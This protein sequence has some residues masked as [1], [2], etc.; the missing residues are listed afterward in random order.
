MFLKHA[1]IAHT[2][3]L[4]PNLT[5]SSSHHPNSLPNH[6]QGQRLP[7]NL[8]RL[9]PPS[10]HHARHPNHRTTPLNHLHIPP[11]LLKLA[12]LTP[13]SRPLYTLQSINHPLF[14][15]PLP[16]PPP[17]NHPLFIHPLPTPQSLL[18]LQL[19]LPHHPLL[20][21]QVLLNHLL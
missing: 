13:L 3:P 20:T 16:I 2:H 7:I 5:P 18:S 17:Q 15:H 10:R 9:P 21:L 19:L 14:T 1:H 11:N 8:P 4:L 12:L 6:H